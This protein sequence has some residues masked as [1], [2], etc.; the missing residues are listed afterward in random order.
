MPA[1]RPGCDDDASDLKPGRLRSGRHANL[2]DTPMTGL[3]HLLRDAW[4]IARPYWCSEDRWAGRGLLLVVVALNLGIV[5]IN[6]LLNQWS[7]T[8]YTALQDEDYP[9][10]VQ[11]LIRFSRLAGLYIC[12]AV[13]QLY[14]NQMLQIRW[15]RW[16]TE[17]YLRAAVPH[18][19][20]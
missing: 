4:E 10:F 11:Q 14:L 12:A 20:G 13:Y 19:D 16:L 18:G 6:V 7:N 9:V 8:F 3:R 17:R 5:A 15:R 2:G 1:H